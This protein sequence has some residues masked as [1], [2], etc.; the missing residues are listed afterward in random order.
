[1][2]ESGDT[3]LPPAEMSMEINVTFR[4]MNPS[5]NIREYAQTKFKRFE[6]YLHEPIDVHVVLHTEKIRQIAEVT[7]KAKNFHF[8]GVEESPDL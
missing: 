3:S 7:V 2:D 4:H 6:R 8:H 1:M 5:Q